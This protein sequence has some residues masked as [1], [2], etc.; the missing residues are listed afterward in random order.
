M[1]YYEKYQQQSH[2]L[3]RVSGEFFASCDVAV[4]NQ[5]LSALLNIARDTAQSPTFVTA[6]KETICSLSLTA[7]HV[8]WLFKR[9]GVIKDDEVLCY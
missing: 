2:V 1:I 8:H 7:D 4:Q 3:S 5:L 6:V 9:M